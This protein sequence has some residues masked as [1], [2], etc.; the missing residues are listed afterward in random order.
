MS[1]PY[2]I[3]LDSKIIGTAKQIITFF[4][5]G[6]FSVENTTIL[7]KRY[8]HKSARQ[9]E[10]VFKQLKGLN[11]RFVSANDIDDLS[12]GIVFYPF[13]AQSNCRVVANRKLTHIFITHGESN[14]VASIKPIIRIYDYVVTAGQVG[15]DRFLQHKIFTQSDVD[16]GR[17]IPMGNTFIGK[18]GLSSKGKGE[19]IIFYAPTWEG[20]IEQENYSS[21]SSVECV[22]HSLVQC[23]KENNIYKVV[24]KPH[25]N[26]GHREKK[27]VK[28]LLNIVD[29]L[30]K[31][32][33]EVVLFKPYLK[34]SFIKKWILKKNN[35]LL[36]D[37]L[38]KYYARFGFCDI[39]AMETQFLNED[40]LYFIFISSENVKQSTFIQRFN[41]YKD[42]IIITDNHFNELTLLSYQKFTYL[43]EAL[44]DTRL[45]DLP[46]YLRIKT[47]LHHI[48]ENK[49]E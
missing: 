9:L 3:Y 20:G 49:N 23:C 48:G 18:T 1:L 37:D 45:N 30:L 36:I 43:K 11:Y 29:E 8:K 19:E 38:S 44:I 31:K 27:Y 32:N 15:I 21:L 33:I 10:Q 16:S 35:V 46:L 25:P 39:S 12:E 14:K 5:N 26:T 24:I 47:Y 17:I 28:Y 34:L 40:I 13:N 42:A 7:I 22:V 6:V 4:E 41:Y 2:F